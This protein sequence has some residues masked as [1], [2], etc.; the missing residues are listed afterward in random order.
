VGAGAVLAAGGAGGVSG[1]TG[2][3]VWSLPALTSAAANRNNWFSSTRSRFC[4]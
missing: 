2:G 3:V 4:P 1:W